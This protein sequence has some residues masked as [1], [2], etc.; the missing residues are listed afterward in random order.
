M[1]DFREQQQ[2]NID[3]LQN[4][5]EAVFESEDVNA[6]Q[7]TIQRA[8]EALMDGDFHTC[9]ELLHIVGT[10]VNRKINTVLL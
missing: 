3:N 8:K 4:V 9:D 1:L 6:I 5:V 7:K 2:R 10:A